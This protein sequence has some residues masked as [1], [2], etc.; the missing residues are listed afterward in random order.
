MQEDFG[1]EAI[2]SVF[3]PT[4]DAS[5]QSINGFNFYFQDCRL[6]SLD[7]ISQWCRFMSSE[8]R[9]DRITISQTWRDLETSKA[10]IGLTPTGPENGYWCR[11]LFQLTPTKASRDSKNSFGINLFVHNYPRPPF[12][13][14]LRIPSESVGGLESSRLAFWSS[15]RDNIRCLKGL[16]VDSQGKFDLH[17][18][19]G[20]EDARLRC[21]KGGGIDSVSMFVPQSRV[22]NATET[23]RQIHALIESLSPDFEFESETIAFGLTPKQFA[24]NASRMHDV[25]RSW[26]FAFQGV[27]H[28]EFSEDEILNSLP[29]EGYWRL[30]L[31]RVKL[32]DKP[33]SFCC[34]FIKTANEQFLEFDVPSKRL[35]DFAMK[36]IPWRDQ[37]EFWTGKAD[38]RWGLLALAQSRESSTQS[39]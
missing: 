2:A 30:P 19:Q 33:Y 1:K 34:R 17:W 28:K 6:V 25:R 7:C 23:L 35:L 26:N 12:D 38:E 22:S 24:S 27:Y 31:L 39:E 16:E 21:I 37:L 20:I 4:S 18:L 32:R 13:L 8:D 14:E 9:R 11:R 3:F 36:E 29:S 10:A 15:V 5:R